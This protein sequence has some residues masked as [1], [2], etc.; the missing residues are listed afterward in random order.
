VVKPS[1]RKE[2][3]QWLRNNRDVSIR[4]ACACVGI[5]ESCYRYKA[6]LSDE[7][8]LIADWLL[9]LTHTHKR[10]GFGL[11]YFYLRNVKLYGWNHK[12]IYRIY[13]ELELNLRIKPKRRIKRDRLDPL[14]TATAE[15]QVWSMDFMNDALADGRQLRT[16]NVLDDYSRDSLGIEVDLSLPSERV[17]RS[18]D[19]VIE[20]RG[21]PSAIRADNGP[22]NIAKKVIDWANE[23]KITLIYIQA[24]KP[25]RNAYIERFNRTARHEWLDLH[26]FESVQH[27]Q[28]LATHWQWTCNNERP[29]TAIGVVPPRQFQMAA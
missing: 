13:C 3:A 29:N 17:I 1:Q 16:F 15:N 11:C 26:D 24:G 8:A 27:A 25:T 23:K 14:G 5:S 7:N 28:I 19:Q 2:M 22:E 21:K 9:R 4:T 10:W 18:F 20:W 12:R 6:K